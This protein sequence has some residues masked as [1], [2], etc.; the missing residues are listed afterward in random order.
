MFGVRVA[1]VRA[2][3]PTAKCSVDEAGGLSLC[4]PTRSEIFVRCQRRACQHGT[5]LVRLDIAVAYYGVVGAMKI[6]SSS[7]I[8][9][10]SLAGS[11]WAITAAA[12]GPEIT[13]GIL[14]MTMAGGLVYLI[15][16]RKRG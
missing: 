4:A 9:L 16:R 13:S 1:A 12:P 10:V 8:F 11:A 2:A 5:H 7:M 14:G 15:N 3:C 6:F